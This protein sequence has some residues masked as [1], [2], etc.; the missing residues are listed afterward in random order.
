MHLSLRSDSASHISIYINIIDGDAGRRIK[1]NVLSHLTLA[2]FPDM[3]LY[4]LVFR[5]KHNFNRKK[6]MVQT[7]PLIFAFIFYWSWYPLYLVD[8]LPN[9][10]FVIF[11]K[12]VKKLRNIWLCFICI[13]IIYWQKLHKFIVIEQN[14][15]NLFFYY[16]HYQNTLLILR[17]RAF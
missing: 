7:C 16:K 3:I 1:N 4:F 15:Y 11:K 2:F 12:T 13:K 17:N 10:W 14:T 6:C 8:M 9:I 5:N